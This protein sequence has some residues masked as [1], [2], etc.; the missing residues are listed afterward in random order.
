MST[1]LLLQ[2]LSWPIIGTGAVQGDY[3]NKLSFYFIFDKSVKIAVII[4][5][6]YLVNLLW[7]LTNCH[8]QKQI[9]VLPTNILTF[10]LDYGRDVTIPVP[11]VARNYYLAVNR[12]DIYYSQNI[13]ELHILLYI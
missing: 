9:S 11:F 5:K 6:Y 12:D 8:F 2:L 13:Y 4:L 7:N 1:T 3:L 10:P